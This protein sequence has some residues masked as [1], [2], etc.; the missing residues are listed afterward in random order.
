MTR[1]L[2]VRKR[3]KK[4]GADFEVLRRAPKLDCQVLSPIGKTFEGGLHILVGH[5]L[6]GMSVADVAADL[7]ERMSMGVFDCDD[8]KCD[9]CIDRD[10]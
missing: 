2:T 6:P 9:V 1:L 3:V 10:E 5:Q 7:L 4:L 8:P